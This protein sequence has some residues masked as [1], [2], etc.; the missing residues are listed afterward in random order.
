[1][2]RATTPFLVQQQIATT[3]GSFD[4]SQPAAAGAASSYP[5]SEPASS[6]PHLAALCQLAF[7]FRR[8]RTTAA[9]LQCKHPAGLACFPA[10]HRSNKP[11]PSPPLTPA[12]L[13]SHARPCTPSLLAYSPSE[14]RLGPVLSSSPCCRTIPMRS[15]QPAPFTR[16][17]VVRKPF[18]SLS[19]RISDSVAFVRST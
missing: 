11:V 8:A 10:P 19:D 3:L 13:P 1:L 9:A 6:T 18:D 14:H 5:P 2:Y 17:R 15:S 7:S 4:S 16:G 12:S